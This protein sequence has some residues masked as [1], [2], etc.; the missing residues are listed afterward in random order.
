M[1]HGT[2]V[3]AQAPVRE[4]QRSP[5]FAPLEDDDLSTHGHRQAL[6]LIG[7]LL[8]WLLL[9][10]AASRSIQGE[11]WPLDSV[12]EYYHSGSV[13][14]L[15]GVLAAFAIFLFTYRGYD[16]GRGKI[17]RLL[18]AL[19]GLAALAVSVFPTTALPP[20]APPVWWREWMRTAHYVSAAA[21]FLCFIVYSLFLFPSTREG[22]VP[23]GEKRRRN[24]VYYLCGAGMVVCVA[25]AGSA[26]YR[27]QPIFWQET[28][29]LELFGISWL[30]KGKLDYTVGR[31]A[32]RPG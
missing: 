7:I 30:A 2:A 19:A 22:R 12:S 6:G 16:N 14:V 3:V 10:V 31:L 9:A 26:G 5:Y 4:T 17:D 24:R 29:A 27:D 21:L 8:P 20:F 15:T 32:R 11:P 25:W 18:G 1:A 13:A 28:A 23:S